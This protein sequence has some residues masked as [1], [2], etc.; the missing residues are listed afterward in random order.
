MI[1]KKRQVAN[2]IN[3]KYNSEKNLQK[4]Q[5]LLKK[6]KHRFSSPGMVIM[7][8]DLQLIG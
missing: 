1:S 4:A 2:Q 5:A 6:S 3:G 8:T 7:L